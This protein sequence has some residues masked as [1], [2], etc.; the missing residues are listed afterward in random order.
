MGR[1]SRAILDQ[2]DR[3]EFAALNTLFETRDAE[4]RTTTDVAQAPSRPQG[5]MEPAARSRRPATWR[6]RWYHP[7]ASTR[8]YV[9]TALIVIRA[10]VVI[11]FKVQKMRYVYMALIVILAGVV[12]LFTVQNFDTV[13]VT[14]FST[15]FTMPVSIL[16]LATYV[17][18]MFTGGF[19]LQLVRSS[20]SGARARV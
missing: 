5:R 11:L 4:G 15:R 20:I 7:A 18:G 16:V 1:A 13:T 19:M 17:L 8:R 2:P 12:I 3:D 9:Y 6:G 14:L 10:G